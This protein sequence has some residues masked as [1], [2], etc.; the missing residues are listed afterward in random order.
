[1]NPDN[2]APDSSVVIGTRFPSTI[3]IAGVVIGL[4]PFVI[5]SSSSSIT[6]VN[7]H[8]TSFVYRDW[9]SLSCGVV[10]ALCGVITVLRLRRTDA[11]ARGKRLLAILALL[12]LGGFQVLRG[13]GLV[14]VTRPADAPASH[15]DTESPVATSVPAPVPD[16]TPSRP[17]VDIDTPTRR[18]FDAWRDGHLQQIYDEAHPEFRKVVPLAT[19]EYLHDRFGEAAGKFVKLGDKLE[20]TIDGETLIVAGDAIFEKGT[21]TFEVQMLVD[22]GKPLMSNFKLQLPKQLQGGDNPDE[23]QPVARKLLDGLL[24]GKLHRELFDVDLQAK[25][26]GKNLEADLKKVLR[27]LGKVK[28][29]AAPT[30]RECSEGACFSYDVIGA[31]AKAKFTADLK[32]EI[33]RW[34]IDAFNIEVP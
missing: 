27:R 33:S 17:A 12:G 11:S 32:F 31:K 16:A 10:A 19:L 26:E 21:L 4:V 1:V 15:L 8:V 24:T 20:D 25:A 3:E 30:R 7:G 22:G 6:T 2:V 5:S 18:I 14:G 13:V 34:E 23:A 29:V 9:A 28:R